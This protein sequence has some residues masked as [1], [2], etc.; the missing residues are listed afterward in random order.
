MCKRIITLFIILSISMPALAYCPTREEDITGAIQCENNNWIVPEQWG[1]RRGKTLKE[2]YMLDMQPK[3][4][5][6][7]ADW[8]ATN[9]PKPI[10]SNWKNAVSGSTIYADA[11]RL[12]RIPRNWLGK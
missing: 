11:F 10:A 5:Q 7:K 1:F 8:T 3:W 9:R 4:K 2:N 6:T 12:Y